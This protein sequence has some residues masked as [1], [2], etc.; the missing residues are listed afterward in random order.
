MRVFVMW[1]LDESQSGLS[2]APFHSLHTRRSIPSISSAGPTRDRLGMSA[3][4]EP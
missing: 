3:L 4:R 2:L 1:Q